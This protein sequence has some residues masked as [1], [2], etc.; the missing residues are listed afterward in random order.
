MK[1][2][3]LDGLHISVAD[4]NVVEIAANVRASNCSINISGARNIVRIS[5]DC[6]L[7]SL[8]IVITSD[9]NVIC[10][11][12]GVQYNGA[13][14]QKRVNGNQVHIGAQ[15]TFGQANII[16][17]EGRRVTI[18]ENCMFAWSI[19][20]RT[21][22]SHGLYDLDSGERLNPGE[23]ITVGDNVWVAA[24]THLMKGTGIPDGCVVAMGSFTN[25]R[26]E[27]PACVLAGAPAQIVRRKVRWEREELG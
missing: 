16:C 19:E 22:D 5:E 21:T 12:Q 6:V 4:D 17:G 27:E 23:D 24:K 25:S 7:N 14:F 8:R 13:I 2:P 26:Y 18:G 3:K 10:L 15:S 1:V 11:G 20:I 9:D